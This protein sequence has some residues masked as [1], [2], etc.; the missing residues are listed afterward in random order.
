MLSAEGG[1][2][3]SS[4]QGI[5]LQLRCQQVLHWAYFVTV[6]MP[7]KMLSTCSRTGMLSSVDFKLQVTIEQLDRSTG[8]DA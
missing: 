6:S 5:A 8:P 3:D 4:W 7:N 1:F 2:R